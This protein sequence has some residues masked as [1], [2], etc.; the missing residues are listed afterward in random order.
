[1]PREVFGPDHAF[2]K[3]AALL[4]FEELTR[5][6]GIFIGLGVRK[7]RITGGEPMLRSGLETLVETIARLEGLEDLS[8]TTNGSLLTLS[9]ARALRRAGLRRLTVSLD[10]L[11][12]TTFRAMNDVDFPVAAVLEG[13]EAASAAGFAPA[14]INMVVRR[15]FN[16]HQ[17]VPMADHFRG[18]GHILRFVE[19][20]DV[21]ATNGWRPEDVVPARDIVERIGREW[22]L[23]PVDPNYPGE[24]AKRFRYRDGAGEVGLIASVT[25]PFCGGCTRA[26]LSAEGS[27]YTCLF[28]SRGCDLRSAL[29]AGATDEAL[30]AR[31]DSLWRRRDDRYSEL[32]SRVRP[33]AAKIEMSYIGG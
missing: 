30:V 7:I 16:E 3:R 17:V 8:L 9:R 5:V 6:A 11:D 32:R 15:G 19:Y 31:I 13:I 21:G 14:K 2:L 4:S 1:M 25:Q 23:E 28:A 12:D 24:V 26:R 20:M 18:T 29:R 10:A 27:V 33:G 22:P